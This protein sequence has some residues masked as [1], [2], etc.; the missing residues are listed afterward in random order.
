[1]NFVICQS[2]KY[3]MASINKKNSIPNCKLIIRE[4]KGVLNF[5]KENKFVDINDLIFFPVYKRKNLFGIIANW[6]FIKSFCFKYRGRIDNVY[7]FTNSH[8]FTTISILNKVKIFGSV[9]MIEF[10]DN[11]KE[12][13]KIIR[14]LNK[15]TLG[16]NLF[17]SDNQPYYTPIKKEKINFLSWSSDGDISSINKLYLLPMEKRGVKQLLIID[18]NDQS[19]KNLFN[20]EILYEE[21]LSLCSDNNI[22]VIIKG[23]PRLGLSNCLKG[24]D[25]VVYIANEIPLEFIFMD[26]VDYIVGFYSSGLFNPSFSKKAKSLLVLC[27][28]EKEWFYKNYL[29]DNGFDKSCFLSKVEDII[30]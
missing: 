22:Q 12:P 14:F 18:S 28:S 20:V 7:A 8:D 17:Y 4:T 5:I 13:S 27:Q 16:V 30:I 15:Y 10:C 21:I 9:Y 25:N 2:P 24:L 23:H 1:M 11:G 19:N 29:I 26:N 6:F 3:L